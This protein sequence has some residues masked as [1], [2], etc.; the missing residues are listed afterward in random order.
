[1]EKS[2]NKGTWPWERET[3]YETT[4]VK[5]DRMGSY[6]DGQTESG[7]RSK[8]IWEFNVWQSGVL[9]QWEKD[10][11]FSKHARVAHS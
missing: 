6:M 10:A 11:L 2:N 8:Y 3:L 1:M 4:A 5:C 9:A 7:H